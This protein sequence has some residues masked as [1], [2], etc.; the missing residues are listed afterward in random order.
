MSISY[1]GELG[2]PDVCHKAVGIIREHGLEKDIP[3][4]SYNG[5]VSFKGALALAC[6]SSIKKI[7]PWDGSVTEEGIPVPEHSLNLFMETVAYLES[8]IDQDIDEW[9]SCHAFT[10]IIGLVQK[11]INRIEIAI[12]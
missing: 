3:Y 2:V 10:D 12:T 1:L 9:A 11:A 7:Q 4:N 6:G 5:S 8:L